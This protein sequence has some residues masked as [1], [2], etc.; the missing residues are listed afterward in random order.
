MD[1][2]SS[3][4]Y[5]TGRV[6]VNTQEFP[7]ALLGNEGEASATWHLN[8][9]YT[10]LVTRL[11]V[12]DESTLGDTVVFTIKVDDKV[13]REITMGP[14]QDPES[15]DVDLTGAFRVELSVDNPRTGLTVAV[16]AWIDPVLT[17]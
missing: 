8:R 13:A 14:G 1:D 17:K 10:S 15:V 2:S 5:E 9:E 4:N 3:W 6:R 12:T 7:R 11:G 16:G